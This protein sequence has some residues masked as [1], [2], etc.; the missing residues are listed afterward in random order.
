MEQRLPF[1]LESSRNFVLPEWE[2]VGG[3]KTATFEDK[4]LGMRFSAENLSKILTSYY[5]QEGTRYAALL[6]EKATTETA[7]EVSFN[8]DIRERYDLELYFLKGPA[9]GKIAEIRSGEQ[10]TELEGQI[11]DGYSP[12]KTIDKLTL[13][14]ALLRSGVNTIILQVIG[15]SPESSG[16]DLAFIGLT[17]SP[18][19]RA[20]ISEWN[21]IGPFDAP[22]MTYLQ[23]SYPPETEI[24]L[25]KSYSGKLNNKIG[26]KK[27]QAEESG[28]VRLERLLE[29]NEQAIAYGLAYVFSPEARQ[30]LILVGSDDGVRVWLNDNLIHDNPAYR[31]AYPDQDKVQADLKKGWNK[32]L[33]KVQQ[34][35]GGWGYYLRFV[36]PE[37]K[38]SWST[39]PKK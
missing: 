5:N 31:G 10:G 23:Q 26:W 4:K 38:L 21:I 29:P 13:Q 36:D 16:M 27:I 18:S 17:L 39:E 24:D 3:E 8:V 32:L 11:F 15:K 1:A 35:G 7:A 12:E 25:R 37:E 28:Y 20:F 22:D 6:T 2:K 34:G 30:A 9:M 14:N 33:I 19:N